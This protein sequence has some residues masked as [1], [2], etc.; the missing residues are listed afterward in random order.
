MKSSIALLMVALTVLSGCASL[1]ETL[2]ARRIEPDAHTALAQ[3]EIIIVGRILFIENGRDKAPYGWGKPVWQLMSLESKRGADGQAVRGRN[4]P[5]LRTGKDGYFAYA[6][7]AGHYQMSHVEPIYYQPFID[8]ALEFDANDPGRVY[9]LGDLEVDI[10]TTSWLGGLW[11]NYITHLNYLEVVDRFE[12]AR[13]RFAG[14]VTGSEPMR[15]ALLT[16]IEGRMPQ[17]KEQ[18]VPPIIHR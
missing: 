4:I 8:P 5:L 10:D 14:L 9:Y 11:G 1:P 7:P 3:D 12:A 2:P 15:K 17:S 16:R 18:F 6:I 13:G